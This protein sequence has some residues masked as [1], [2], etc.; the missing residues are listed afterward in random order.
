MGWFAIPFYKKIAFYNNWDR[1][2]D[3]FDKKSIPS[4]V[5]VEL[6]QT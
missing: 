1:F 6:A 2:K 5:K 4:K 3:G